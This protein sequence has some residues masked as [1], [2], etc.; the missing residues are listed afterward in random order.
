MAHNGHVARPREPTETLV[1]R[2]RGVYN[3]GLADDGP[4]G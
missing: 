2:L 1:W 3:N 4:M